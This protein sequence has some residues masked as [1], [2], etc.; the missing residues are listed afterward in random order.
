MDNKKYPLVFSSWARHTRSFVLGGFVCALSEMSPLSYI[1]VLLFVI[2]RGLQ[3]Q[4]PVG[5]VYAVM[6]ISIHFHMEVGLAVSH[7]SRGCRRLDDEAKWAVGGRA[8]DLDRRSIA[9]I[10]AQSSGSWPWLQGSTRGEFPAVDV[11][12]F[13]LTFKPAS[14]WC[15]SQRLKKPSPAI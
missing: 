10:N 7:I 8:K 15:S 12:S 4:V 13:N 14:Q 1:G 2:R 11:L 9:R 3:R 6:Q 5:Y